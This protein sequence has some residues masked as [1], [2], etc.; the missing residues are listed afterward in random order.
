MV[1]VFVHANTGQNW[2]EQ[3][4]MGSHIIVQQLLLTMEYMISELSLY[5]MTM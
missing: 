3:L 1:H 4:F 2:G 5:K